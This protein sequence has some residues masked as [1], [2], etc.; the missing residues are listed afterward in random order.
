MGTSHQS[1]LANGFY[2]GL[3]S[4]DEYMRERA[5]PMLEGVLSPSC[6]EQ[7]IKASFLRAVGWMAS[8]KKLNNPQDFQAI[9]ACTRALLAS[10]C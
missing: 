4:V 1:H 8:L 3:S 5:K 9:A 2:S 7:C 10:L 6:R